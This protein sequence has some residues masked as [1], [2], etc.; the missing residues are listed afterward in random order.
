VIGVLGAT[1]ISV[2]ILS[3]EENVAKAK[4]LLVESTQPDYA[5][6]D[7]VTTGMTEAEV[8]KLLGEPVWEDKPPEKRI[9]D[10]TYFKIMVYGRI[11]FD[12]PS[13]PNGFDFWIGT[14]LGKVT[15]KQHPF[16][17]ALSRDGKPTIPGLIYPRDKTKFDHYP[18]FVDLRWQPSSGKYPIEYV[19]DVEA[20]FFEVNAPDKAAK[21]VFRNHHQVVSELP[22]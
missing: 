8:K 15:Q 19:V 21:R 1:A 5:M 13:M 17:G 4:R 22:Y 11:S 10:P 12:S 2:P 6:W 18:R 16:G 9:D 3:A 14:Q 7:S 20:G